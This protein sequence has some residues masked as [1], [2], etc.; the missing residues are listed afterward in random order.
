MA[1]YQR[2]EVIGG[3]TLYQANCLDL[4]PT[5]GRFE[6][7][8][9]DPPYEQSLHDAKSPE[10]TRKLR[11]DGCKELETLSFAGIDA[12]RDDV[13]ALGQ[14]V[15]GWFMAF[16]TSEGIGRWADAIN[17]SPMNYKRA[18]HWIKPDAMPQMNGQGPAQGAEHFVT[19]WAGGGFSR[20]NGGGK[21]GVYTEMTNPK[22]R[23]GGH[24]TEKPWR[25]MR[26]ILF[27]FTNP[28]DL[29][30]DFFM[31]SGTTLVAAA[32]TGRRAIGIEL[33]PD[34]FEMACHRVDKAVR[35]AG[36]LGQQT[37]PMVQTSLLDAGSPVL[38]PKTRPKQ[39][40]LLE[41]V[42]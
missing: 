42:Q 35:S 1:L 11:N 20:W 26:D 34:Y 13:V 15:D 2:K 19:A 28:G 25:L 12:I 16:C 33:N 30:A 27:D 37:A 9:F 22:D 38:R 41:G 29:I 17:P 4:A 39:G 24:P 3:M 14:Q 23:H 6:H 8:I 21:R 40:D 31:G 36:A 18:C 10:K 5:L 32:L 7:A